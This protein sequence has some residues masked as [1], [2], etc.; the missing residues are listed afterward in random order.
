MFIIYNCDNEPDVTPPP[1]PPPLPLTR[2]GGRSWMATAAVRH[3]V[4]QHLVGL[5]EVPL[6]GGH[7][8]HDLLPVELGGVRLPLALSLVFVLCHLGGEQ[9]GGEGLRAVHRSPATRS[10]AHIKFHPPFFKTSSMHV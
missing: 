6:H 10:E 7:L 1:P 9:G 4:V 2:R 5:D 8:G 3:V